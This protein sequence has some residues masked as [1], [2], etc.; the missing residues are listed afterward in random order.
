[1]IPQYKKEGDADLT[2][3]ASSTWELGR[4]LVQ[5]ALENGGPGGVSSFFSYTTPKSGVYEV[6]W[7]GQL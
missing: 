4:K 2:A 5:L 3:E 1:M 6:G 7:H